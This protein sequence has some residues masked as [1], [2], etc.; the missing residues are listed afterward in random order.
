MP[1]CRPGRVA[2]TNGNGRTVTTTRVG[3]RSGKVGYVHSQFD[4]FPFVHSAH[5]GSCCNTTRTNCGK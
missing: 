4:R 5:D 1:D 2:L 3:E